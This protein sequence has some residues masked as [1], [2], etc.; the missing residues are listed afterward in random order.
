M[1][2]FK[3]F[4]E[5]RINMFLLT[6]KFLIDFDTPAMRVAG[7]Y[8]LLRGL[9]ANLN[10]DSFVSVKIS[11]KYYEQGAL[12]NIVGME[13]VYEG[14]PIKVLDMKNDEIYFTVLETGEERRVPDNVFENNATFRVNK[15]NAELSYIIF[16]DN[17]I[18]TY[19]KPYK[20]AVG[21]GKKKLSGKRFPLEKSVFSKTGMKLDRD[22]RPQKLVP[23]DSEK[24]Y[25]SECDQSKYLRER[26]ELIRRCRGEQKQSADVNNTAPEYRLPDDIQTD[27]S[28]YVTECVLLFFG[29]IPFSFLEYNN[30]DNNVFRDAILDYEN[31][32]AFQ[33]PR[34]GGRFRRFLNMMAIRNQTQ[35]LK[36]FAAFQESRRVR[37][38]NYVTEFLNAREAN[39]RNKK[40]LSKITRK[41]R[42]A[43][44]MSKALSLSPSVPDK[45][46]LLR[47]LSLTGRYFYG[48]IH[49]EDPQDAKEMAL[50][51]SRYFLK[52][53]MYIPGITYRFAVLTL[54][55]IL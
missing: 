16:H 26:I 3:K 20:W 24:P 55:Y 33:F 19:G 28:N 43:P 10:R 42:M 6:N 1:L 37:I 12:E 18:K 17:K 14:M 45:E 35:F 36:E 48:C 54:F 52:Y 9:C 51:F 31:T 27:F 23:I 11:S 41:I 53:K 25:A 50:G 49:S 46:V 21:L 40:K 2:R 30:P 22:A 47:A 15:R 7:R 5:S 13:G 4:K 38:Q 29:R 39:P 34:K 32:Y 8:I 44:R